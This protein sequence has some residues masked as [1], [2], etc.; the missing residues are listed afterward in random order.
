MVTV[1]VPSVAV[2]A[3]PAVYT[4]GGSQQ[5]IYHSQQLAGLTPVYEVMDPRNGSI[6]DVYQIGGGECQ[7]CSSSRFTESLAGQLRQVHPA[8]WASS[9]DGFIQY[10]IVHLKKKS[11]KSIGPSTYLSMHFRWVHAGIWAWSCNRFIKVFEHAVPI[12]SSRYLSMQFWWVR[13]GIWIC[14]SDKFSRI[15]EHAVSPIGSSSGGLFT[16]MKAEWDETTL[17]NSDECRNSY[18]DRHGSGVSM[19]P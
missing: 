5:R 19:T 12:G 6:Y 7:C 4:T 17:Y 1:S 10:L 3:G 15:F 18:F 9:S 14:S 16:V 11:K 2:P 8:I 13:Q